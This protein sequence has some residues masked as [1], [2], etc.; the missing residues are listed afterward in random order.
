MPVAVTPAAP[1]ET[2]TGALPPSVAKEAATRLRE[3]AE[4]GDVSG[5]AAICSE[6]TV[7][8]EAFSPYAARVARLADDFDF[9]GVLKLTEALEKQ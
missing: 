7:K 6:L 2:A 1:A 8:S 9:D 4:L 3:A 5:L